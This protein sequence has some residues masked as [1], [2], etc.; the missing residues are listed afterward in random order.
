MRTLA[1]L[2]LTLLPHCVCAQ[3]KPN[4]S[5]TWTLNPA[6]SEFPDPRVTPADRL[7]WTI[8]HKGEN[9][10]CKVEAKVKDQNIAFEYDVDIAG[11]PHASNEA[12]VISMEWKGRS[13]IVQTLYNPQR[14][15]AS[16][17]EE[18]WTLSEDGKRLI[19]EVVFH[20][21]KTAK[22]TA[23]LKYKRVFE[24]K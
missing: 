12:G 5:G 6:A 17:R 13:L 14:E 9:V 18:V 16:S 10:A 22:N 3:S 1:L 20:P 8:L 2:A 4:F 21:P 23:D 7:V 15:N 24:K 19:D 11:S